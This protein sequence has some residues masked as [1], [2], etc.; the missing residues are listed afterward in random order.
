MKYV[1]L[2]E[3]ADDVLAKAPAHFEAHTA[4]GSSTSGARC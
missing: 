2:Y 3:S 4:R 1:L